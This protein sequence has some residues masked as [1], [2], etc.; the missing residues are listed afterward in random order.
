MWAPKTI[1]N[2]K[3]YGK[4]IKIYKKPSHN[5][6]IVQGK[7]ERLGI[8]HD[9]PPVYSVVIK[10]KLNNNNEMFLTC[11]SCIIKKVEINILPEISKEIDNFCEKKMN[12]DVGNNILEYIDGYV[13]I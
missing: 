9:N 8:S 4:S 13:E 10:H 2:E 11:T 1:N 12:K 3:Y 5:N 6:E 7:F